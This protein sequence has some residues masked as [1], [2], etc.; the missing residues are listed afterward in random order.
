MD[1]QLSDQLTGRERLLAAAKGVDYRGKL[2]WAPR[3]DLWYRAHVRNHT[4]PEN[5]T[6]TSMWDVIRDLGGLLYYP[7]IPAWRERLFGVNVVETV[8]GVRS[9]VDQ[10]INIFFHRTGLLGL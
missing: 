8:D 3:L 4:L 7:N 6:N 10:P 9:N 2:P 1:H 5:W